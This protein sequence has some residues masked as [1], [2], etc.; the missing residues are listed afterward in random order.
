MKSP[1]RTPPTQRRDRQIRERVHDPYKMRDKPQ[2]PASCPDCGVVFADGRWQWSD[3]PPDNAISTLCPACQRVRDHQPAG[4]VTLSGTFYR[5]H[6]EEMLNL[7]RNCETAAKGERPLNR[8][9]AIDDEDDHT[10][11]T[12]TEIHLPRRIG[13]ALR[14]AYGG[15]LD[16]QYT[17]EGD[18]LRV[19]WER[20]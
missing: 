3:T 15:D 1:Q 13:N 14:D 5:E 6:K 10:V 9:M 16:I 4:Y 20:S 7:V 11:I 18:S 17:P 12:T 19:T 2:S 8:I